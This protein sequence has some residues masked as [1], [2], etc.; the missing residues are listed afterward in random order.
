MEGG[1]RGIGRIYSPVQVFIYLKVTGH[2]KKKFR[3]SPIRE[4]PKEKNYFWVP[5]HFNCT[6]CYTIIIHK[7]IELEK[8][9]LLCYY[10]Q[11]FSLFWVAC[12]FSIKLLEEGSSHLASLIFEGFREICFKKDSWKII[13]FQASFQLMEKIQFY[14]RRNKLNFPYIFSFSSPGFV[15]GNWDKYKLC[16]N[17][18]ESFNIL[19]NKINN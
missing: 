17:F 13:Y 7:Y 12:F 14:L 16:E 11:N 6:I 15:T 9:N 3:V 4:N 5:S 1:G 2:Q 10:F 19:C 18:C 8:K